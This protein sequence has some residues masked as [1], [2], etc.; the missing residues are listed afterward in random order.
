MGHVRR[1]FNAGVLG[2][3]AFPLFA[4]ATAPA[5]E[6]C[7]AVASTRTGTRTNLVVRVT[8]PVPLQDQGPDGAIDLTF[9]RSATAVG[10][11]LSGAGRLDCA[12]SRTRISCVGSVPEANEQV[13][14]LGQLS[15]AP[16]PNPGG[17]AISLKVHTADGR[18]LGP[19]T[20][21]PPNDC[22]PP[23]PAGLVRDGRDAGVAVDVK[24][25]LAS[26][27]RGRLRLDI[28]A[29]RAW[30][31]SQAIVYFGFWRRNRP[32]DPSD[33]GTH[34]ATVTKSQFRGGQRDPI[35]RARI[36]R[37]GAKTY[38]WEIATSLLGKPKLIWWSLLL[39]KPGCGDRCPSES[40]P[41]VRLAR[42]VLRR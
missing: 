19:L 25:I 39:Q 1:A 23:T 6:A 21:A 9:N 12:N 7:S 27:S 20:V 40:V 41:E 38:R 36:K 10:A 32:H 29:Y 18:E 26:V 4:A 17:I 15:P 13:S 24:Q 5:D 11:R 14:V 8:C 33:Y 16:C 22:P 2:V 37:I 28:T 3:L 42:F 34:N 35:G 30:K 31:P